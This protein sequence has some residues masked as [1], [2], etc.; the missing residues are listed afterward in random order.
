MNEGIEGSGKANFKTLN[1]L[2]NLTDR[3]SKFEVQHGQ[4][5]F[6]NVSKKIGTGK[7]SRTK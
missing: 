1:I 2:F 6:V 7:D 4:K 5:L 3:D